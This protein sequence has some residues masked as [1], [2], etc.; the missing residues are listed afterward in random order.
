MHSLAIDTAT[1]SLSVAVM[2]DQKI[3]EE[4]LETKKVRHS[5]ALLPAIHKALDQVGWKVEDIDRIFVTRGPGSYTGLRMGVTTAKTL[6]WTMN[7]ELF[8]VSSLAAL[9]INAKEGYVF[10]YIDARRKFLFGAG[11]LIQ[12][13]KLEELLPEGYYALEEFLQ[14]AKEIV[15]DEKVTFVS[16]NGEKLEEDIQTFFKEQVHFL[17]DEDRFIHAGRE[18]LVPS[19]QEVP[20]DFLPSYQKLVEAEEKWVASHP[21]EAKENKGHYVEEVD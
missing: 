12:D 13:G 20:E 16:S 15:K 6:A 11:Y 3:L 17:T 21:Q 10:P 1:T 9:A 4:V 7:K 14:K 18:L 8:S 2:D 5:V 19:K